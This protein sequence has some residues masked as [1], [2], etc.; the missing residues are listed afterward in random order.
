MSKPE[1]PAR[2]AAPALGHAN[3]GEFQHSSR[4]CAVGGEVRRG[5]REGEERLANLFSAAVMVQV[6]MKQVSG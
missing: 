2:E 3:H 5:G 6:A 4:A 1:I